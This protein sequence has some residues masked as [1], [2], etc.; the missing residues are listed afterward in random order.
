MQCLDQKLICYNACD[1]EPS[2]VKGCDKFPCSKMDLPPKYAEEDPLAYDLDQPPEWWS[3][4]GTGPSKSWA[5]NPIVWM[6]LGI[7]AVLV[8]RSS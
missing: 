8:W 4:A 5:S 2:C 6:G 1:N 7:V 3:Q